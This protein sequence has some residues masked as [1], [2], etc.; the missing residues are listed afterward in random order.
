[1]WRTEGKLANMNLK[2]SRSPDLHH[3]TPF[4]ILSHLCCDTSITSNHHSLAFYSTSTC[5][6]VDT[7]DESTDAVTT[8]TQQSVASEVCNPP[9]LTS[10]LAIGPT[11]HLVAEPDKSPHRKHPP[12]AQVAPTTDHRPP[13][14][15]RRC[16]PPYSDCLDSFSRHSRQLSRCLSYLDGLP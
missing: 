1:V 3:H 15:W 6:S 9:H 13:Q 7:V 4:P 10:A 14:S 2:S 16:C 11:A 12:R 5:F 8:L